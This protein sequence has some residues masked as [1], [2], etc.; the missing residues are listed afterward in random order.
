MKHSSSP[1]RRTLPHAFTLIELLVVIALI[2]V[3]ASLVMVASASVR[4]KGSTAKCIA[5]LRHLGSGLQLYAT[6]HGGCFPRSYHSAGANREP[7]WA[8]SIAPYVGGTEASSMTEWK[9]VFNKFFRCPADTNSDPMVYSYGLNVFF[10]LTPDGD[11]YAGAPASWRTLAS[12]SAP[13]RTILLAEV[14]SDGGNMG[15]DHFMCHQWS[16]A[17]AAKNAVAHDRHAG[18]ANFLFVDGHVENLAVEDTFISRTENLWN[19]S[20]AGAR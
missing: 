13:G 8:A 16:S 14:K 4:A 19:P 7:G 12:V 11:D 3:L 10:E 9:T 17:S 18:R 20:S 6:D 5:N 1:S 15:G 2:A